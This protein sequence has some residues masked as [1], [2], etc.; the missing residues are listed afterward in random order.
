MIKR[1]TP[2]ILLLALIV[3]AFFAYRPGLTGYFLFDDQINIVDNQNLRIDSL[4]LQSLGQAAFSGIAS[5]LGRPISM[6]SFALNYLA[7]GMDP[8][9]FKLTNVFIHLLNGLFVFVL[10]NLLLE[11]HRLNNDESLSKNAAKWMSLA[12]TAAWMLHPLNMSSVLYIVQRMTSLSATFTFLGLICYI[13][14]RLRTQQDKSGWTWIV[15]SFVILTPLALLSKENGALLPAFLLLVECLFFRFKFPNRRD[16]QALIALFALT[17]VLPAILIAI[18]T[19]AHPQWITDSYRMRSF[20]LAER[21]MTEARV[22]WFYVRLILVPDIT[23]LSMYHDDIAISTTLLSPVT[24][25]AACIGVIAAAGFALVCA[26]RRPIITFG[27][28]FFLI[29]HCIESSV[30]SLELVHEHR[31]YLPMFGLLFTLFYYLL[32]P[33]KH[34]ESKRIRAL[35][36]CA[37]ILMLAGT[38]FLRATTWGDAVEMKL[39]E[40]AHHPDSVRT[41]L[42]AG[43]F[44][45]VLPPSN[46]LEATEFYNDAYRY[47][48][49]ASSLSPSDT[50]GLLGLISLNSRHSL[51][52]EETWTTVLA[53]RIEKNAFS[54]NTGNSLVSL[55]KCVASGLCANAAGPMEV[56]FQA[57][58]RN[59]TLSGPAKQGILFAWSDYLRAFKHDP[60]AAIA[61]ANQAAKLTPRDVD[62]QIN[63]VVDLINV[64][65]LLEAKAIIEKTR[66]IDRMHLYAPKLDALERLTNNK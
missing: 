17:V 9:Y 7:N 4:N 47:Y 22:L 46:Q 5:I 3:L 62:A 23:T 14:G 6:L 21:V 40:V 28:L 35:I 48:V 34:N 55:Y 29:G 64:G 44:Y 59:P 43:A 10:A 20:T 52:I 32:A 61:V 31:N 11:A 33:G 1:H 63:L 54:A 65:K 37:F 58:F 8:Y 57:A 51:P 45:A 60:E 42:E 41:N 26:K 36:A 53:Q 50:L 25:L 15:G 16:K 12:L 24:T 27:I 19:A 2:S 39:K 18:Y 38:T 49:Q 13:F 56:L 30:L 66:K